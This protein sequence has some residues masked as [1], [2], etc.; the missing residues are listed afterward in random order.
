MLYAFSILTICTISTISADALSHS[1]PTSQFMKNPLG[2]R[3]IEET[4][5]VDDDF[6]SLPDVN[7][8]VLLD[9]PGPKFNLT[10]LDVW[11]E[12]NN[13]A[14]ETVPVIINLTDTSDLNSGSME[15]EILNENEDPNES[16]VS[17]TTETHHHHHHNNTESMNETISLNVTIPNDEDEVSNAT[18]IHHHHHHNNTESM[19]ETISLNA[20]IPNEEDE[21]SNATEIHHHHH[22]NNTESMNETIS[23]NA[24][25]PNEE[26]EIL[27]ATEIHHHHHHN[28]TE[29]MN[30]TISL[31]VTIPQNTTAPNEM[32]EVSNAT[33]TH[34]HRHKNETEGSI[35][36]STSPSIS[37]SILTPDDHSSSQFN[38]PPKNPEEPT[39]HSHP[40]M[41]PTKSSSKLYKP[42]YSSNTNNINGTDQIVIDGNEMKAI[43]GVSVSFFLLL[44]VLTAYQMKENPH[45][46]CAG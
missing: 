17:S 27:N 45:G 30:E 18:E 34:H 3:S 10:K 24:T 40:T 13:L 5:L 41:S 11:G 37:P 31:N 39:H 21:V 26:D 6:S 28:D 46:L 22:H 9:N 25:I 2:S 14:N 19:N 29:N 38:P 16:N 23:L 12:T 8:T 36:I 35:P 42:A 15:S 33:E 4:E 32:G 7:D 44:M 43:V 20:T 1:L